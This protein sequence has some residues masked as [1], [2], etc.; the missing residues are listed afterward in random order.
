MTER[1]IDIIRSLK[2]Q[3]ERINSLS[4]GEKKFQRES[5]RLIY[6]NVVWRQQLF[7]TQDLWRALTKLSTCT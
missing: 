7:I 6:N 1:E 5:S 4:R 2:I 3:Q